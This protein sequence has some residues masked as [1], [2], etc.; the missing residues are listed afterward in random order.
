[1]YYS[2]FGGILEIVFEKI[3][4]IIIKYKNPFLKFKLGLKRIIVL[5]MWQ[6]YI[7]CSDSYY[8][9]ETIFLY[10][11]IVLSLNFYSDIK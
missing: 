2:I 7:T 1:M 4:K 5:T 3:M 8:S 6:K 10:A 11:D 9:G